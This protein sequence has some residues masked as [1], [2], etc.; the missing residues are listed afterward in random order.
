M[1]KPLSSAG[2]GDESTVD[3]VFTATRVSPPMLVKLGINPESEVASSYFKAQS[4]ANSFARS[5]QRKEAAA[6]ARSRLLDACWRAAA[7]PV[8]AIDRQN[9]EIGLQN[10]V[11]EDASRKIRRA[12]VAQRKEIERLQALVPPADAGAS[13]SS[14]DMLALPAPASAPASGNSDVMEVWMERFRNQ[15]WDR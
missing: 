5:K 12:V 14:G 2:V 10:S 7:K 8:E 9:A 3:V 6:A 11:I 4:A 1:A 13:S 15:A